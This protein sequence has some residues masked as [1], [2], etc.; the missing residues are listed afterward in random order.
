MILAVLQV[1]Y[2]VTKV[3]TKSLKI[4]VLMP[5]RGDEFSRLNN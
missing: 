4:A 5:N 3:I 1:I 2:V